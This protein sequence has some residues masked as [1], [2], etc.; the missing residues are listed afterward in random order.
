[1]TSEDAGILMCVIGAVLGMTVFI[2]ACFNL[3]YDLIARDEVR[4]STQIQTTITST[5]TDV[6]VV[7][8]NKTTYKFP[9]GT[10]VVCDDGKCKNAVE[11]LK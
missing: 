2:W 5:T 9:N 7:E 3:Y 4:I 1:M 11:A 8:T 10:V 6:T